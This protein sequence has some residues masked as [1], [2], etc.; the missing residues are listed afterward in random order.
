MDEKIDFDGIVLDIDG[1]LWNTTG[2]VAEGWNRAIRNWKKNVS[3]VTPEALKKEFGK[4]MDVIARDLWPELTEEERKDLMEALLVEEHAEIKNFTG[5]ISYPGVV[6]TIKEI[7]L[8]HNVYIVS[9]CQDGYIELTMEKLGI[10]DCIKDFEC[11]GRT[12]KGKAENILLLMHRNHLEHPFYVGDT[13]GDAEACVQACIPFIWAS[14]GF[15]SV[16]NYY[17]KIDFFSEIKKVLEK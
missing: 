11:F 17:E 4:P 16:K 7:C 12:G 15:G 9:N 10:T 8:E 13:Q 14:Y 5:D 2:V 1:T 6:D 3:E